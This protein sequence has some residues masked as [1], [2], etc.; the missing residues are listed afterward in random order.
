MTRTQLMLSTAIVTVIFAGLTAFAQ[1]EAPDTQPSAQN[2]ADE[3]SPMNSRMMDR[4]QSLARTEISPTDPAAILAQAEELELSE[5]Q[6]ADL[7]RIAQTARDKA[8]VVLNEDQ[9]NTLSEVGEQPMS[10]MRMH[11]R[12][13]DRMQDGN[14]NSS[15]KS[16]ADSA[17]PMHAMMHEA[18]TARDGRSDASSWQGHSG[19]HRNRGDMRHCCR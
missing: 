6:V 3:S 15:M 4:C 19:K 17:C 13:M 18:D 7:Q 12:M 14:K 5:Q 11:Q 2:R 1:T 9:L 16:D 10:M 8:T